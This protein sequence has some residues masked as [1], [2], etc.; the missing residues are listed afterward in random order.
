MTVSIEFLQWKRDLVAA[1]THLGYTRI[2]V[3]YNG[4]NDEGWIEPVI[5]FR[6]DGT[7]EMLEGVSRGEYTRVNDRWLWV[8]R[9]LSPTEAAITHVVDLATQPV[10]ACY[11]SWAGEFDVSDSYTID[12]TGAIVCDDN[13]LN[14]EIFSTPESKAAIA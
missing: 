12:V 11:G 13:W 10:D 14:D 9:L 4:G 5:G 7:S 6:S 3:H 8:T 1:M 2:E